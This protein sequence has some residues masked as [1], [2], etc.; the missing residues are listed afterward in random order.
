MSTQIQTVIKKL[1]TLWQGGLGH[2][3]IKPYLINNSR[4]K[5]RFENRKF[6]TYM[7]LEHIVYTWKT[8]LMT[9]L[10]ETHTSGENVYHESISRTPCVVEK[11]Y[12]CG[13]EGLQF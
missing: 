8:Y 5:R 2:A 6:G 12:G 7:L 13:N 3:M 11:Q 1:E 10:Q 9:K 4:L